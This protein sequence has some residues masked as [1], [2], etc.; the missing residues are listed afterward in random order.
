MGT[1][2][3]MQVNGLSDNQQS[4]FIVSQR[5]RLGESMHGVREKLELCW[6]SIW[7]ENILQVMC[8]FD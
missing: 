1:Y 5:L 3:Y 2:Y 6:T 8:F 4:L 7:K